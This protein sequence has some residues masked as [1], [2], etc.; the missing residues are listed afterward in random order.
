M[1]RI[2]PIPVSIAG[3][4]IVG[5]FSGSSAP[6]GAGSVALARPKSSTFDAV[7]RGE[8]DV[9]RLE[10]AVD[11][12]LVVRRLERL[13]RSRARWRVPRQPAAALSRSARQRLAVDQLEHEETLAVRFLEAVNAA[14]MRVVQSGE[15]LRFTA[16]PRQ[17]LRIV[18]DAVGQ[19]LQRNVAAEIRVPR[20]VDL[21]HPA[22]AEQRHD[23]VGAKAR[24]GGERHGDRL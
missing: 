21:A 4:V 14:D 10:I 7:V 2:T 5:E 20:P 24:A 3:D 18:R 8:R 12:P 16:K 15:D 23:L 22:G 6:G 19:S 1:P 11:D 13:R 9:R 17:A